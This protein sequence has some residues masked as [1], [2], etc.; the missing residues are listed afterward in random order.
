MQG[1][2]IIIIFITSIVFCPL[3]AIWSLN[4][5]FPTLLI[6]YNFTTWLAAFVL[7]VIIVGPKSTLKSNN[8]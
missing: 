1:L 3:V 6:P 4:T 8:S 7:S 2:V 5:L